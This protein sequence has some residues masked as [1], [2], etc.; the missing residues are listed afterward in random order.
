MALYVLTHH[1]ADLMSSVSISRV[2]TDFSRASQSCS[3]ILFCA[4]M[5][6]VM[7]GFNSIGPFSLALYGS[8]FICYHTF[9]GWLSLWAYNFFEHITIQ[10]PRYPSYINS[11]TSVQNPHFQRRIVLIYQWYMINH[12]S[13]YSL[14]YLAWRLFIYNIYIFTRHYLYRVSPSGSNS[15]K[16]IWYWKTCVLS[17]IRYHVAL[18]NNLL[19]PILVCYV[20]LYSAAP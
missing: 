16:N 8:I 10:L 17:H 7:N 19:L 11:R 4:T 15:M 2:F 5:L 12:L 9:P 3:E 1:G 20:W 13:W 6:F 14:S 18:D